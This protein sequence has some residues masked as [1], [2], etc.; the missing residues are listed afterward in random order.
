MSV[1]Y[2]SFLAPTGYTQAAIDNIKSMSSVGIDVSLRCIHGR[3][4][5]TGMSSIEKKWLESLLLKKSDTDSV[6]FLH[7]IPPRWP[8]IRYNKNKIA[9]FVFENK[10][11]PREWISSLLTC[12]AVIVPSEFNYNSCLE[13]GIKNIYKVNHAIDFSIWNQDTPS[14]SINKEEDFLKIITVGTWR[15]RKN[16]RPMLDAFVEINK[17]GIK[18]KWTIKI[19]K[20]NSAKKD[21][22]KW[23]IDSNYSNYFKELINIDSRVLDETSVARL[24]KGHDILLSAS[25]GEGFGLPAIQSVCLG[26]PVVCPKYGGYEEY[27]DDRAFV[28][29]KKSGEEKIQK[30][31]NLHQFS[32]LDWPIYDKDSIANALYLCIRKLN[33]KEFNINYVIDK[34]HNNFNHNK[35]GKDFKT[36]IERTNVITSN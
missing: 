26:V 11:I 24:V 2:F 16:W 31:D 7:S 17:N 18:A 8:K 12:S 3:M 5:S 25:R 14:F 34:I 23:F 32:N 20:E 15:E 13:S 9:L 19:D 6:Q 1:E 35:I 27:F 28:E 22:E 10:K 21:I 29:I 4:L 33:K 30:L 36:I